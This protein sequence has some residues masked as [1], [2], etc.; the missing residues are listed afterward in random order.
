MDLVEDQ[1][2]LCSNCGTVLNPQ[3]T[4]CVSCGNKIVSEQPVYTEDT[5]TYHAKM[6]GVFY[7]LDLLLVLI[8]HNLD[9]FEDYH[10]MFWMEVAMAAWTMLFVI[11][12]FR[13][14]LP[15]FKLHRERFKPAWLL[16]IIPAC[17]AASLCVSTVVDAVNLALFEQEGSYYPVYMFLNH[18]AAVMFLSIA[19]YP[20][21]F[22]ELAYRGVVYHHL[23]ELGG[24]KNAWIISSLGFA[25]IH[26][27]LVS[28][29]WLVPFALFLGYI[30]YKSGSIWYGMIIH[31]AFNT[32]ACIYDMHLNGVNFFDKVYW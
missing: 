17:V 18:P 21:V 9:Y 15:L 1:P 11:I 12:N 28:F 16:L 27:S 14:M 22:E 19:I 2:T 29:F 6:L 24:E 25:I 8:A 30:R 20:A 3:N 32:T 7:G 23:N 26:I 4:F 31:M 10:H 5:F 13:H